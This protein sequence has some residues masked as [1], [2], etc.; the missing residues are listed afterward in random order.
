MLAIRGDEARDP[1]V[2]N[3]P[4][5]SGRCM[6]WRGQLAIF[7]CAG[8]VRRISGTAWDPIISSSRQVLGPADRR[9]TSTSEGSR[10]C[11]PSC[12]GDGSGRGALLRPSSS[13][14]VECFIVELSDGS[15]PLSAILKL[16]RSTLFANL[17]QVADQ[18]PSATLFMEQ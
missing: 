6:S 1:T 4:G 8:I 11:L 16:S 17:E 14:D 5:P 12:C 3:W 15:G 7:S 9:L 18:L 13:K 2:G 10:C